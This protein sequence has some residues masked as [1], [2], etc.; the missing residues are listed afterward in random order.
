VRFANRAVNHTH[1]LAGRVKGVFSNELIACRLV[2]AISESKDLEGD[3]GRL[4]NS[5]PGA[6]ASNKLLG[7]GVTLLARRDGGVNGTC[8]G[9][10]NGLG[11]GACSGGDTASVGLITSSVRHGRVVAEDQGREERLKG[12]SSQGRGPGDTAAVGVIRV[13]RVLDGTSEVATEPDLARNHASLSQSSSLVGANVG[14]TAD[15]LKRGHLAHND[16]SSNHGLGGN[17]HG[18]GQDGEK[19]LGDD[20]NSDADTVKEDI[21]ANVP[22]VD[23]EDDNGEDNGKGEQKQ[24]ELAK[25]YLQRGAFQAENRAAGLVGLVQVLDERSLVVARLLGLA[26]HFCNL[27]DLGLHTGSN[28]NTSSATAGDRATGVDEVDAVAN[29]HVIVGEDDLGLLGDGQ[30]FTGQERFVGRQVDAVDQTQIGRD[31]VTSSEGDQVTLDECLSLDDVAIAAANDF[32][33]RGGQGVE[34]LDGLLSTVILDQSVTELVHAYMK[35]MTSQCNTAWRH[36][37]WRPLAHDWQ[38]GSD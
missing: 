22:E 27:T 6:G 24:G 5:L 38:T 19:R 30:G 9:L 17:S 26:K 25:G 14:N 20:G 7:G 8:D 31:H 1:A 29:G 28:D 21:I 33:F 36:W 13:G 18:D 3:L 23:G 34:R 15:G 4:T 2:S 35:M 11:H 16:V 12:A 32:A 10:D 37:H